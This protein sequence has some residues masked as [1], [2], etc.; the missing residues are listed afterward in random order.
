MQE[1]RDE[2]ELGKAYVV[3]YYENYC[4]HLSIDFTEEDYRSNSL[5]WFFTMPMVFS[6]TKKS[7]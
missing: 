5:I 4:Y 1:V 3:R 7:R 6:I 2:T